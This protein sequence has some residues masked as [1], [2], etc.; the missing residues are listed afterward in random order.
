MPIGGTSAFLWG[1]G[2]SVGRLRLRAFG[3]GGD[4]AHLAE[5]LEGVEEA[6]FDRADGAVQG[7]SDFLKGIIH[8]KPE[9]NHLLV[10]GGQGL[11]A[12]AEE[13]GPL[14]ELGG[15]VR[16]EGLIGQ[17]QGLVLDFF[18]LDRGEGGDRNG[19][20]FAQGVAV[21]VQQ[22]GAEPGEELTASVVAAETFPSFDEGVLGEV[23]GQ[24]GIAAEGHGLTN[25]SG[26][27]GAAETAKGGGIAGLR[28]GE[29]T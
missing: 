23:F 16:R 21:A 13:R 24:G 4:G 18:P 27:M 3:L 26:L 14:A 17:L 8:I 29:E 25:Q 5:L 2:S 9:V 6:R 22:D 20:A 11:D 12:L 10:L 19:A 15:L 7:G 1:M 28:P